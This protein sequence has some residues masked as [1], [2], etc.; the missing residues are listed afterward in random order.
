MDLY[1]EKKHYSAMRWSG[2]GLV[3]R[4]MTL[5][6]GLTLP[7]LRINLPCAPRNS[8]M[9]F[10]FRIGYEKYVK[11]TKGEKESQ[12]KTYSLNSGDI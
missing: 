3:H 4:S 7:G 6:I 10:T 8:A 1:I 11:R 9:S 2:S 5:T 12:T